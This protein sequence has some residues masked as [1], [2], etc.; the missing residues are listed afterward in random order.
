MDRADIKQYIGLPPPQAVYW[1][2]KSC[3][4]ELMR[5]G[6][7]EKVPLLDWPQA[8]I[9]KQGLSLAGAP[10][11]ATLTSSIKLLELAEHCVG[12]SGR[13]L[14]KLPVL[15]HAKHIGLSIPPISC[16]TWV[17]ALA[18]A[19]Q[20]ARADAEQAKQGSGSTAV[21]MTT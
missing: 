3:V 16:E 20:D 12:L 1:I 10:A 21:N 13:T 6:I 2:L 14:R 18:K 5:C 8:C 19:A 9:A 15:A 17:D 11:E 4:E 7:A